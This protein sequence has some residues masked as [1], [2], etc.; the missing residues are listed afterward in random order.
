MYTY[1]LMPSTIRDL[2]EIADYIANV[3]CAPESAVELLNDIESA[4]EH[5]CDFP[6]SLPTVQDALLRMKGY[7]K[8]IVKNYIVFVLLEP[9][10]EVLNVMRVMYH[11][12]DYLKEL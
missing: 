6:L 1:R 5:A 3:L 4:I 9:K 8:I 10:N 2:R 11:A 7:R 12:R